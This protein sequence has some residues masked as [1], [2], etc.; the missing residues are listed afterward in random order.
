MTL[1]W[2]PDELLVPS[3]LDRVIAILRVLPISQRRKKAALRDWGSIVGV[4]ITAQMVERVTG[5]PAG[6]V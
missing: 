3:A 4:Q 1:E 6:E 5:R 2:L